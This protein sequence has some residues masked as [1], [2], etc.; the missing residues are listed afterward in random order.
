[1]Y[2]Y[3][4]G[5]SPLTLIRFFG[6]RTDPAKIEIVTLRLKKHLTQNRCWGPRGPQRIRLSC[7]YSLTLLTGPK[8]IMTRYIPPGSKLTPGPVSKVKMF[9]CLMGRSGRYGN[10]FFQELNE[11]PPVTNQTFNDP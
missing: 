3:L 9:R 8:K 11:S 7:R 5:K 4:I 2:A 6:V 1:M 10:Y